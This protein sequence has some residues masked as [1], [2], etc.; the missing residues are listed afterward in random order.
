MSLTSGLIGAVFGSVISAAVNYLIVGVPGSAGVNA[1]NHGISGLL[2]GFTAGFIGLLVHL[3]KST[4]RPA[5]GNP[6]TTPQD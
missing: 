2:S 4:R 3:R 1:L 5:Q 6:S